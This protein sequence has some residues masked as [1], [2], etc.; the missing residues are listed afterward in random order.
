MCLAIAAELVSR[1]GDRGIARVED[2]SFEVSLLTAP[3]ATPGDHLLVSLGMA[4]AVISED[5][6]KSIRDAW[7]TTST[8]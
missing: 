3:E 6:A 5:E 8:S 7:T 1:D 4:L 2:R